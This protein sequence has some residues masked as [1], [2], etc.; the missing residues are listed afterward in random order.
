M[1]NRHL[2]ILTDEA[3][4]ATLGGFGCALPPVQPDPC[5]PKPPVMGCLPAVTLPVLCLPKISVAW[6]CCSAAIW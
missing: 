1:N 2:Q 5:A 4:E 6:N 3:C